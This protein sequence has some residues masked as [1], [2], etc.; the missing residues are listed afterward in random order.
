MIS[1]ARDVVVQ[2]ASQAGLYAANL[3]TADDALS[4]RSEVLL[5][6]RSATQDVDVTEIGVKLKL[7][8]AMLEAM[9]NAASHIIPKSLVD[10]LR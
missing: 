6:L 4:S 7:E 9:L 3:S 1:M 10:F 8:Q 5:N 2:E